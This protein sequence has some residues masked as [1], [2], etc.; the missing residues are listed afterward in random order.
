VLTI[1]GELKASVP[2]VGGRI[3]KAAAPAVAGAFHGEGET[4]RRWLAERA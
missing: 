3:E 2:L 4:G 1:E